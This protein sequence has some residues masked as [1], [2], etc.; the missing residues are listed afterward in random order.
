MLY[1][2]LIHYTTSFVVDNGGI[3]AGST[4]GLST[5]IMHH[6]TLSAV[7]IAQMS[8]GMT[9]NGS[10]VVATNQ[11]LLEPII[12]PLVQQSQHT[13]NIAH[14]INDYTHVWRHCI[15]ITYQ[16]SQDQVSRSSAVSIQS[17]IDRVWTARATESQMAKVKGIG[18]Y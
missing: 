10:H 1:S 11:D 13:I 15:H 3:L 6:L 2:W 9:M 17:N 12:Q 5:F 7:F 16:E 14:S 4:A 18:F 8:Y